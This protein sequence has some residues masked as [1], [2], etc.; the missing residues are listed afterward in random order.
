MPRSLPNIA[1]ALVIPIAVVL[2]GAVVIL[3]ARPIY[4]RLAGA[5]P[6]G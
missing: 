2:I 3:E 5:N 6:C 4:R 1:V